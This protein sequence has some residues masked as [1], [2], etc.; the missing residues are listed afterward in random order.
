MVYVVGKGEL[1]RNGAGNGPISGAVFVADIAG[2]DNTYGTADDCTGGLNGLA[3]AFFD[4]SGGGT[5][6][7]VFCTND[8]DPALPV[9]P[10]KVREF[11]QR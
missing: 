8:I 9:E 6:E 1:V 2:P 5:G 3:P 4:E 11:L 7:H 10:Y